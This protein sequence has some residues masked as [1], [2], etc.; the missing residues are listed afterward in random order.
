MY[1]LGNAS[2]RNLV[3]VKQSIVAI[4]ERAL[5][6]SPIDFGVPATGGKRTTE[7]QGDMHRTAGSPCD[8]VIRRSK[9]QDGDAVDVFAY[10]NGRASYDPL[11]LAII[12]C[13]ILQAASE[14]GVHLKWGGLW[15]GKGMDMPHFEL[16][17]S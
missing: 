4:L 2:K 9:H 7:Q 3:G 14:L 12:S 10:I 17:D 8:G 16:G 11:K 5:E 15:K 1:K 13:A 6:I